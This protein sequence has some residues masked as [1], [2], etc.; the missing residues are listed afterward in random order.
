VTIRRWQVVIAALALGAGCKK[1][2]A[3]PE[4]GVLTVSFS[5]PT[6]TDGALLLLVTGPVT[7]IQVLGGYQMSQ[8]PAGGN[9]TRVV[10]TGALISGDILKL[11]VPDVSTAS[12]YTVAVEAAADRNTFALTDENQYTATV[13]K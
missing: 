6:D 12:S 13:R 10:L 11:S 3:G 7:S 2:P 8:A 4:A 5:S 1:E 9:A